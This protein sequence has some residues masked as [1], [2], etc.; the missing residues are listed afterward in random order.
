MSAYSDLG[1]TVSD[2]TADDVL[3]VNFKRDSQVGSKSGSSEMTDSMQFY[4]VEYKK[5]Y[6]DKISCHYGKTQTV[7]ASK[8]SS[9]DC[10]RMKFDMSFGVRRRHLGEMKRCLSVLETVL[11]R[12]DTPFFCR[13]E[14]TKYCCVLYGNPINING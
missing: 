13:V 8:C 5:G 10:F 6:Y 12:V 4:L 7:S 3:F 9:P 1:E 2:F 11:T 14:E